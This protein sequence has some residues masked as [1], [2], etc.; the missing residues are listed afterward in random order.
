[1]LALRQDDDALGAAIGA[2]AEADAATTAKMAA[3]NFIIDRLSKDTVDRLW[4]DG[5]INLE[6]KLARQ[7]LKKAVRH[8]FCVRTVQDL[9]VRSMSQSSD[10]SFS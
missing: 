10:R 7:N 9:Y 4:C 8:F 2:K 3:V 1:M 6:M 5:E